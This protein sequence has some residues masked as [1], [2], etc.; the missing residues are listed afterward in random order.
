MRK[1][2]VIFLGLLTSA[3]GPAAA[4]PGEPPGPP[5]GIVVETPGH[6]VEFDGQVL[7]HAR[8]SE[9]FFGAPQRARVISER[10]A[11]LARDPA[12][13]PAA[14]TV[15]ATEQ[16]ADIMAGDRLIMPIEDFLARLEG[17]APEELAQEYAERIRQAL[18]A[19]QEEHGY[20][21][22]VPALA[23]SLAALAILIALLVGLRRLVRRLTRAIWETPRIRPVKLGSF[24]F[25]TAERLKGLLAAGLKGL[26][27]LGMVVLLYAFVHLELSFF[28]R[29]QKYAR[30]LFDAVLQALGA[31]FGALWDQ[32]PA[33]IFL[34]VLFLVTRYV[35]KTLNFFFEQVSAGKVAFPGLDAEVA[36]ITYKIVRL[37]VIAFVVV[38]AYPYIPGSD[39]PAFKGVSI[40]LGVLFSL[41]STAAVANLI[42]GVSLTY[43]RSFQVGDVIQIGADTGVVLERKLY[44]TRIRTFKNRVVTIP[45]ATILTGHVTNLSQEVRQGNGLIL[46]T[47]VTIGY[48]VPWETVYAL[49]LKAAAAT[50]HILKSPP[51]FVLQS[52]LNDFYVTYE[53]NAYTDAPPLLA[54]IYSEMHQNIRDTFN[55]A[56]VEIMSPH[57][58]QIRDGHRAAIPADYLPPDY[59]PPALRVVLPDSAPPNRKPG[60]GD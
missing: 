15:A 42:A 59:T 49:L 19:H 36:P 53:L 46:P 51:P 39:S 52:A 37:L 44:V 30:I 45:N 8:V 57:Y 25:F 34:G 20:R 28:P 11:E 13:R 47:S 17:R 5:P 3:L 2:I 32:V 55:E 35:L 22:L 50:R 31:I 9:K 12:F 40:F 24:E 29:T 56:G 43:M 1:L 27:M 18:T 38:I 7:F 23:K 6:P 21:S 10:I 33:L 41:G 58:T 26:K 14:I 54:R 16:G 4:L 60:E 48:D